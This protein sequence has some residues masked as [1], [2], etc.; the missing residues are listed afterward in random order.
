MKQ[1]FKNLLSSIIKFRATISSFDNL[2][3]LLFQ[4][5][6]LVDLKPNALD[7]VSSLTDL[8]KAFIDFN[9]KLSEWLEKEDTETEIEEDTEE[10]N[11]K[12]AEEKETKKDWKKHLKELYPPIKAIYKAI[13][14]LKDLN[15]KDLELLGV[16][17][18]PKAREAFKKEIPERIINDLFTLTLER[19]Y[20]ILYGFLHTTGIIEYTF[21]EPP[22][23][24]R[25]NYTRTDI[26]WGKLGDLVSG[27][28]GK[29]FN[30]A[31]NW[32]NGQDLEW[33]KLLHAIE[34]SFLANRFLMRYVLPRKSVVDPTDNHDTNPYNAY[35]TPDYM[36]AQD[37]HELQLP[38]IYGTSVLDESFYNISLA[39]MPIAAK[40]SL[41]AKPKGFLLTPIIQGG[42]N[43]SFFLT[44][45]I[46]LKLDSEM[47]LTNSVAVALFP[48]EINLIWDK[49][50][51]DAA[52][53]VGL[54]GSPYEP[55]LAIGDWES[56]RLELHGFDLALTVK[57]N[58][59]KPEDLEVKISLQTISREEGAKGIQTVILLDQADE[60]LK[61]NVEQEQI[62]AG[63]DFLV[64]WS[65]KTG[66]RL[67]GS[68]GINYQSQVNKK[69]G[70]IEVTNL[71]LELTADVDTKGKPNQPLVQFRTGLGVLGELGPLR[72]QVEN[73]GFAMDLLT[74][75]TEEAHRL[76]K[77]D[78]TPLLGN[79]DIDFDKSEKSN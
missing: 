23:E 21:V 35:V 3:S 33:E 38:F 46:A 44:P 32:N 65:N 5:G 27:D 51:I 67:G 28:L 24:Y 41:N 8:T 4:H 13:L 6:W 77:E 2:T 48:N 71:Y 59:T 40:G 76:A 7:A 56:S 22:E 12:N 47:A 18:D 50:A 74:H 25:I 30:E 11:N 64:E 45:E 1:L 72:F 55:W 17:D 29:L 14:K 36:V 53:S 60:F 10:N 63:L 66:F 15:D 54:E 42:T 31:Y 39:M 34:R 58:P 61:E 62:T 79:L 69:L 19:H 75:S 73:M 70:L 52:A 20:S 43:H 57:G 68:A 37:L 16:F 26:H 49:G 78:K 9:E